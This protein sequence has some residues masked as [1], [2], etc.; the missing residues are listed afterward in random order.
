M[1][2]KSRECVSVA[3]FRLTAGEMWGAETRTQR[4]IFERG[5]PLIQ[6]RVDFD[7]ASDELKVHLA[8]T[9]IRE[10][11]NICGSY[12]ENGDPRWFF[13]HFARDMTSRH[14]VFDIRR[15]PPLQAAIM[16]LALQNFCIF[17]HEREQAGDLALVFGMGGSG[18]AGLYLLSQLEY[19]FRVKSN[20]L[21]IEGKLTQSVPSA[22]A[23]MNGLKNKQIGQRINQ[24]H[25]AFLLYLDGSPDVLRQRLVGLEQDVQISAR[26]S[27]IRSRAMHGT[28]GDP[29]GEGLFY[30]LLV[31]MFYYSELGQSQAAP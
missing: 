10:S 11:T 31:A 27:R 29:S 4:Q 3:D 8:E 21:D 16:L 14:P 6:D 5:L 28:I 19:L 1:S 20:Y 17:Q 25:L 2:G 7:R 15:T 23:A 13:Q 18:V 9:M 26:L 12:S 30:A 24:I 22:L